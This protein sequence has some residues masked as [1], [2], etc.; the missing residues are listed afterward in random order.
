MDDAKEDSKAGTAQDGL[1]IAGG[2]VLVIASV[3]LFAHRM[4]RVKYVEVHADAPRPKVATDIAAPASGQPIAKAAAA[5]QPKRAS[6][7]PSALSAP[8]PAALPEAAPSPEPPA[9]MSPLDLADACEAEA[10]L[11]CYHVPVK[12]LK[13]CLLPYDE[14]L[15]TS[16][17]EALGLLA[18][19]TES[20]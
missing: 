6:G 10:G 12:R 2:I 20:P 15:R 18:A 13:G 3:A 14:S 9:A 8:K 11:L 5:Q 17:R 4:P 7:A 1:K 16:C 19:K